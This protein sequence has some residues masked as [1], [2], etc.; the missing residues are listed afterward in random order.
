MAMHQAAE[1]GVALTLEIGCNM[2]LESGDI[3]SRNLRKITGSFGT[4]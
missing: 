2:N 3:K 4:W 1:L